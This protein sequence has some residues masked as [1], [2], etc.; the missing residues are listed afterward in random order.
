MAFELGQRMVDV[1]T[2]LD[3]EDTFFMVTEELVTAIEARKAGKSVPELGKLA[4]ERRELRE[5]RKLLHPPGTIPEEASNIPSVRFKETQIRNDESADYCRIKSKGA[6]NNGIR[7]RPPHGV[8]TPSVFQKR[9]L[10]NVALFAAKETVVVSR[11]RVNIQP[12]RRAAGNHPTKPSLQIASV[13]VRMFKNNIL[14]TVTLCLVLLG[15][16]SAYAFT[17]PVG[18][19]LGGNLGYA[20]IFKTLEGFKEDNDGFAYSVDGGYQF[21]PYFAL[22][23]GFVGLPNMHAKDKITGKKFV[24]RD[25]HLLYVTSKIMLP[26]FNRFS[27][28]AKLGITHVS[29]GDV[30]PQP[31]SNKEEKSG[32][33][34]LYGGGVSYSITKNIS[35]NLQALVA[36][37]KHD[38]L[39]TVQL[40]L[41]GVSYLF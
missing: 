31:V 40:F 39:P 30:P 36:Q 27:V 20:R 18:W 13:P 34:Y 14:K 37:K 8:C 2:F 24:G 16:S 33:T 15:A 9:T 21:R 41:L 38:G 32:Y 6:L 23:S 7:S 1:G 4:A 5:A 28:F 22:E 26:L 12:L 29:R 19:Y 3:R 35:T 17:Q 11:S 10:S 25:N